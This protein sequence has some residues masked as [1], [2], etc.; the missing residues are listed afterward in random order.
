MRHETEAGP[1]TADVGHHSHSCSDACCLVSPA[2]CLL[3]SARYCRRLSARAGSTF[4]FAFD[5]LPKAKADA[6]HALYAYLRLTDDLADGPG[7]VPAKHAAL[8]EWRTRLH[9][10]LGGRFSHR[11]H[12]A[13]HHTV[14]NFGIPHLLLF[15]PIAGGETDLSGEGFATFDDLRTYCRRVAGGVGLACV[16]IWGVKPGVSWEEVE[17]PA[18]AA[19]LAFQL[20]NI[21]RDLGEDRTAGRVY[22]P[23]DELERFD[24]PPLR[25]EQ[26]ELFRELLRFQV[27]RA[28]RFYQQSEPLFVMLSADGRRVFALMSRAYRGLLERVAMAGPVVLRK[29][30][31]LGAWAKLNLIARAWAAKWTG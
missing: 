17:P 7:E 28:R 31:R 2:S 14:R 9:D 29:R 21:L 18:E 24:C 25:W 27:D 8:A 10:A 4:R 13:L 6:M 16:R 15:E 3:S 26:C 11:V 20:T 22:L 19:G 23:A 5:L 1:G 12:P 30:V